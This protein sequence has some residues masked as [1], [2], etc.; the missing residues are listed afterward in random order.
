MTCPA[1]PLPGQQ[2]QRII[3]PGLANSPQGQRVPGQT[4]SRAGRQ[5]PCGWK[6]SDSKRGQTVGPNVGASRTKSWVGRDR[7]SIAGGGHPSSLWASPP[8]GTTPIFA[9]KWGSWS[10]QPGP[11]MWGQGRA[12][13][14][15]SRG[16]EVRLCVK[17]LAWAP[18]ILSLSPVRVGWI[19]AGQ[20]AVDLNSPLVPR[21][22]ASGDSSPCQLGLPA[23]LKGPTASTWGA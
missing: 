14:Q 4:Q 16:S 10:P 21:A 8:L 22:R 17:G 3:A 2:A 15:A 13:R 5:Q 20:L 19:S 9:P 23:P 12:C 11:G 6:S 1:Q 18:L 7:D